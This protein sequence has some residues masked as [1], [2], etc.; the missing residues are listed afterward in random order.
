MKKMRLRSGKVTGEINK[1]SDELMNIP[2]ECK[3]KITKRRDNKKKIEK[4]A[5]SNISELSLKEL[6]LCIENIEQT[7]TN[8]NNKES[9]TNEYDDLLN[10]FDNQLTVC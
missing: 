2:S 9:N 1:D 8:E 5:K 4:Q 3:K 7:D 10:L 6:L